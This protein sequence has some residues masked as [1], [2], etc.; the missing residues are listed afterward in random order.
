MPL[1]RLTVKPW[2]IIQAV[3]LWCSNSSFVFETTRVGSDQVAHSSLL[4]I[5]VQIGTN[6]NTMKFLDLSLRRQLLSQHTFDEVEGRIPNFAPA[7]N[8]IFEFGEQMVPACDMLSP[9]GLRVRAKSRVCEMMF[10]IHCSKYVNLAS[11]IYYYRYHLVA[12]Y[13][14]GIKRIRWG[15]DL[16][17]SLARQQPMPLDDI[18]NV[19]IHVST[20]TIPMTVD[21]F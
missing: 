6:G 7:L 17:E 2:T 18:L 1:C 8:F 11:L 10:F 19:M 16:I 20:R 3:R 13:S 14:H 9:R 12:I 15:Q 4:G 5:Y 21:S